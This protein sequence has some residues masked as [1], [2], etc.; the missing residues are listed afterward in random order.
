MPEIDTDQFSARLRKKAIDLQ[1]KKVLITRL[2]GSEQEQ[3][4]QLPTNCKGYGRVRH[5]KR[6]SSTGWP[7]NPLPID[8]AASR[9]GMKRPD[10]LLAL[11][12]Q[13]AV[14]NWRCWYCY[15]PW[16]QL[17]GDQKLSAWFSAA[18][19]IDLYLQIKDPPKVIDLSGGQPDLTPEWIVWTMRELEA[20]KLS[21]KVYLWSD[22]NLS[23]D[24]LLRY[25]SKH[26]LE[27]M[28]NYRMYGK[29]CC[30]KGFDEQSF[31]F[32]TNAAPNLFARQFEIFKSHMSLGLDLY[33]YAT[34]TSPQNDNV[35]GSMISFVDKLQQIHHNLP[36][37]TIP[38]EIRSFAPMKDRND[39]N[40]TVIQSQA[41]EEWNLEIEK[42]FSAEER[43]RPIYEV[44]LT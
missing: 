4:I 24:Y 9:L 8:P 3:D 40:A 23:N 12:F 19:L 6:Q 33:G 13:N 1:V 17:N 32:N 26:D 44:S 27:Y 5:F 16:P 10:V 31:A 30:F 7:E 28:R 38:L 22:D 25:L 15:V 42:R 39:E 35:K 20:R 34:F 41:I 14:C 21:D 18:E 11:V 29:V 43:R 37:R 36:L 2:A